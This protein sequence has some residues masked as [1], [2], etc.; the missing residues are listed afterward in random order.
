[1]RL[2]IRATNSF[3]HHERAFP[4]PVIGLRQFSH[5]QAKPKGG[6]FEW[7]AN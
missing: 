7:G 1:M 5:N 6:F 2:W 4:L 3:D